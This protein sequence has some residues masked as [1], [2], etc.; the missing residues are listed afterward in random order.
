METPGSAPATGVFRST[1]RGRH[2]TVHQTPIRAGNGTAGVFSLA[3]WDA[4]HGVA[5]GGD[6]KEPDRA[7]K[8]V[9][10]LPTVAAHGDGQRGRRRRDIALRLL[11]FS[12]RRDRRWWLSVPPGPIGQPMAVRTGRG[13]AAMVSM[14]LR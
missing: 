12:A 9:R 3:F 4:D 8:S 6:F 2:W 10:S 13:S 11:A 5:S 1:D 14:Q 7:G